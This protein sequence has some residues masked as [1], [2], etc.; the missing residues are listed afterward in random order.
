MVHC[1]IL[2]DYKHLYSITS[3]NIILILK[4]S[5]TP[6]PGYFNNDDVLDF[7]IHWSLGVWISYDDTKVTTYMIHFSLAHGAGARSYPNDTKI[8]MSMINIH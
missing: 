1:V 6:A 4:F 3:N 5:R 7:M 2:F 8:T